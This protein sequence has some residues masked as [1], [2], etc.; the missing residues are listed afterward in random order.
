[1][2]EIPDDK[3]I[4]VF[5]SGIWNGLKGA[6]FLGGQV[7][8][9]STVGAR[10]EWKKAQKNDTKKSTS[11]VMKRIIPSRMFVSTWTGWWP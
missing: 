1:M 2:T 3:R 6:I 11:E 10:L 7:I 4:I 5:S 9:I 8:P